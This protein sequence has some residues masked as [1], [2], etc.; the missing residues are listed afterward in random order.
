M[1]QTARMK[2]PLQPVKAQDTEFQIRIYE[3]GTSQVSNLSAFIT[4][5]GEN[6]LGM[7][8]P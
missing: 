4:L 2:P 6:F 8:N 3:I 1:L 7:E 5:K